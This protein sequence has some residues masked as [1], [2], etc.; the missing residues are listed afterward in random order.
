VGPF[1]INGPHNV[2]KG[3]SQTVFCLQ[4]LISATESP[5]KHYM[6]DNKQLVIIPDREMIT[7]IKEAYVAIYAKLEQ[8]EKPEP[9]EKVGHSQLYC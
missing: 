3:Q 4:I 6:L 5:D 8:G 7:Q 2:V 9:F 1:V